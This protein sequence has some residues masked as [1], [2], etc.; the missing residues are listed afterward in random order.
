MKKICHICSHLILYLFFPHSIQR[1]PFEA[2][3]P[4][5]YF[6]AVTIYYVLL[7]NTLV[8]LKCL[9]TFGFGT[10]SMLFPLTNDLKSNLKTMNDNAR[11]RKYRSKITKQLSRFIQF[12]CKL[13]QLSLFVTHN[14]QT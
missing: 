13:L 9:T 2:N 14:L 5:R 8:A 10:C 7:M 3:T 11:R 1:L 6:I 12:H 4:I